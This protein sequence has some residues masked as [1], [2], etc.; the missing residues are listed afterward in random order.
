[1][2]IFL[3]IGLGNPGNGDGQRIEAFHKRTGIQWGNLLQRERHIRY[4]LSPHDTYKSFH[5]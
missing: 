4:I 5:Q 3:F 1:M 2:G